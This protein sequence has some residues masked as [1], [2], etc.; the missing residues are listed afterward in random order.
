MTVA[1]SG[2]VGGGGGQSPRRGLPQVELMATS[3]DPGEAE[4]PHEV[5][6]KTYPPAG[7]GRDFPR[8]PKPQQGWLVLTK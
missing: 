2:Q 3:L 8:L 5:T 4:V 1:F 6:P 7:E